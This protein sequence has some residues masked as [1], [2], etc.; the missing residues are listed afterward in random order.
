MKQIII[1]IFTIAI[2]IGAIAQ[3]PN[4]IIVKDKT[5][6]VQQNK[7]TTDIKTDYLYEVKEGEVYPIYISRTGKAYIFKVS[8]KTNKEYKY[9]LKDDIAKDIIAKDKI[10]I[11]KKKKQ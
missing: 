4:T 6:S 9:Y 8:K 5:Y 2:A 3:N 10:K 7:T 11:E 1:F